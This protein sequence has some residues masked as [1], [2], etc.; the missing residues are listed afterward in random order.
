MIKTH[1]AMRKNLHLMAF[2][3]PNGWIFSINRSNF[4]YFE[5]FTLFTPLPLV[6]CRVAAL[7][8]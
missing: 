5:F 4:R 7:S 6:R 8:L 2:N 1:D 3:H